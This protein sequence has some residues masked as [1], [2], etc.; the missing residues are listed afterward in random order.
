MWSAFWNAWN[1]RH[2]RGYTPL[3]II[4]CFY[5][6]LFFV[7]M[8]FKCLFWCQCAFWQ[9]IITGCSQVVCFMKTSHGAWTGIHVLHEN[10]TWSLDWHSCVTWNIVLYSVLEYWQNEPVMYCIELA[11][12]EYTLTCV[13]CLSFKGT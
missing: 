2:L 7:N 6:V 3:S 5:V 1:Q 10:V 4:I 11:V 8:L 12:W 13:I 9:I